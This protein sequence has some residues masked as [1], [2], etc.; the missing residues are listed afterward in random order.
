MDVEKSLISQEERKDFE[1]KIFIKQ[2]FQRELVKTREI[3]NEPKAKICKFFAYDIPCPD[4]I[5]FGD[6][7]FQ[8]DELIKQAHLMFINLD[9]STE[10]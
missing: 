8:H 7:Q 6:C 3:E 4:T 9:E 10:D 5:E 1:A 2:H